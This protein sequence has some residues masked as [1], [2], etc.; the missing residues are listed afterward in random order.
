M[1]DS[2]RADINF[3]MIMLG[4]ALLLA[5]ALWSP[6]SAGPETPRGPVVLNENVSVNGTIVHL[7]D[8][9]Q[10]AGDKAGAAVAYAP[11]PGRRAFFDVNWLYKVARSYRLAWKPLSL[12]Q[13]AIVRRTSITIDT[14]E[15]KDHIL[16]ALIEKGVKNDVSIELNNRMMRLYVP[17]DS[18][19]TMAVQ[20]ISYNPASRRFAANII[21]PADSPAP[22]HTRVTGRVYRMLEVPVLN[23][24]IAR[25]SIIRARDIK[26]I[27][28]RSKRAR[29][30]VV[31][32]ETDLVG[33]SAKRTLRRDAP[34][35][36]SD[37][38][39]PVLVAKGS[40][41]IITLK[42]PLMRLTS[43]GRAK[44]SGVKGDAIAVL[45]TQSNKIIQATVIGA[46]QVTVTP[47]SH[48]AMN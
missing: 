20:D 38:G 12:K 4:L 17:G 6:A 40:L 29:R 15:I 25:G 33:M 21:A 3:W 22:T 42:M 5:S 47:V 10:G 43:R 9:F 39:Q 36:A 13:R 8:L 19:A 26:W 34:I 11:E 16:A 18:S 30:N 41:V 46:G 35:A 45:N 31:T 37:I 14:E 23:R 27:D 7:G 48:I 28:I 1:K 2:R 44:E 24:D 32:E